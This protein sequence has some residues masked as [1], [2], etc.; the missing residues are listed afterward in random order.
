MPDIRFDD[1]LGTI[2]SIE[3]WQVVG[4]GLG[5]TEGPLWLPDGQLI[6]SDTLRNEIRCWRNGAL[7][8]YRKQNGGPNGLTLD[9]DMRLLCCE[10][11]GRRVWR[12][13]DGAI[14]VLA[15]H[16]EGKRLNSPNDIVVRSDGRIFFTDPPYGITDKERELP[17]NG[18]FTLGVDGELTL[19]ADGFDR[20]NGLAFSPD[21]QTLYIADTSRQHVR[22]FD[23]AANGELGNGRIFAEMREE[24]RPDGM[25]VDRDGRLFVCAS[26]VQVFDQS[27]KPLGI[28]DCPQMPA[29]CAWGEDGSTLFITARTGVYRA[30]LET[31]GIAPYLR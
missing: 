21:E 2:A 11:D 23:V 28:I 22:A 1:G 9:L 8:V 12:E 24:G 4:E 14:D 3:P 10:Q 19:L 17:Y 5:F 6:F 31:T 25:K 16:Y 20:P 18:V 26:T 15:T 7:G 30:H 13:R 27:G 29:N